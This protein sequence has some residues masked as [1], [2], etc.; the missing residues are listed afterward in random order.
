VM[1]LPAAIL[2]AAGLFWTGC[3]LFPEA[4]PKPGSPA[5]PVQA[6]EVPGPPSLQT[7]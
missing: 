6:T 4:R 2:L 3:Q 7:N 5:A 1:T